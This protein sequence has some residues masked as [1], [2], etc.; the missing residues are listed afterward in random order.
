LI[1][2]GFRLHVWRRFP[3][4]RRPDIAKRDTG[5][6]RQRD[7]A[8]RAD[9]GAYPK[10]AH[11]RGARRIPE[12]SAELGRKLS[13]RRDSAAERCLRRFGNVGRDT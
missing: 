7:R 1:G 9:Y 12:R 3:F 13:R 8:N 4:R 2:G 5:D 10:A 6:R 11:E